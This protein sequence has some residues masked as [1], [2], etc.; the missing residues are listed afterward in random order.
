M[1]LIHYAIIWLGIVF[2]T[3]TTYE[4]VTLLLENAADPSVLPA[5]LFSSIHLA[6]FLALFFMARQ[7]YRLIK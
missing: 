1:K 5:V 4:A 2:Y 7:T 6:I 3:V